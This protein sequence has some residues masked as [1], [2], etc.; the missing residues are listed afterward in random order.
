MAIPAP[1]PGTDAVAV[2]EHV[3][4]AS[5]NSRC[6]PRTLRTQLVAQRARDHRKSPAR[7]TGL[8]G[9]QS[10]LPTGLAVSGRSSAN[11]PLQRRAARLVA[12]RE[13]PLARKNP[14]EAGLSPCEGLPQSREGKPTDTVSQSVAQR[15][16][17]EKAPRSGAKFD[18]RACRCDNGKPTDTIPQPVA[19]R[20]CRRLTR[21]ISRDVTIA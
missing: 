19:Q 13:G 17:T 16:A 21:F 3:G 6:S 10:C 5:S 7:G 8:S 2:Y 9:S 4:S 12:C 18:H 1:A 15:A 11:P 20:M 14:A